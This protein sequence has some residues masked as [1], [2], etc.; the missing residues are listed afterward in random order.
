MS[1]CICFEPAGCSG[2]GSSGPIPASSVTVTPAN[3]GDWIT[4]PTNQ[5]QAD[6]ELA[7]RVTELENDMQSTTSNPTVK[8]LDSTDQ[9]VV[10][11]SARNGYTAVNED[12]T[13]TAVLV[14]GATATGTLGVGDGVAMIK[15]A[16]GATIDKVGWRGPI[17]GYS[18][19][20]STGVVE[21]TCKLVLTE[22]FA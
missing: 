18:L 12:Q 21:G 4:P 19:N 5:Q 2:G 6:D 22:K 16:P 13:Y 14:E 3:P 10:P 8:T 17:R 11:A 1:D 20:D 15:V 9:E 7:A